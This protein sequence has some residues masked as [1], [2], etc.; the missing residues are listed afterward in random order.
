M[1]K[2]FNLHCSCIIYVYN[3]NCSAEESACTP[4]SRSGYGRQVRISNLN[5]L[6]FVIS[7]ITLKFISLIQKMFLIELM[8]TEI[9]NVFETA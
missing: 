3:K 4:A 6:L 5:D 8:E 2:N 7:K 1:L 9:E